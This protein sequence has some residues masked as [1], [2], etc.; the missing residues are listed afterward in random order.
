MM[1]S[2]QLASFVAV[3]LFLAEHT[4]AI[5]T[6]FVNDVL[7]VSHNNFTASLSPA[8]VSAGGDFFGTGPLPDLAGYSCGTQL[9][10]GDI[11]TCVYTTSDKWL[12]RVLPTWNTGHESH[13]DRTIPFLTGLSAV[14]I[15]GGLA[16]HNT[17]TDTYTP[18]P[19]YDLVSRSPN[20]ASVFV[21][22]WTRADSTLDGFVHSGVQDFIIVLDNVSD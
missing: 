9:S 17:T 16:T 2:K 12:K 3:V 1:H 15:L 10:G 5:N 20:N 21:Y 8:N 13:G 11:G 22:N 7:H 6:M 19:E 4:N 18:H 14:R